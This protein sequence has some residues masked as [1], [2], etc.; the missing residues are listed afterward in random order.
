MP[1]SAG[2]L[3]VAGPA[4]IFPP[5]T[6]AGSTKIPRQECRAFIAGD[7]GLRGTSGTANQSPSIRAISGR[8]AGQPKQTGYTGSH[9]PA[10][11]RHRLW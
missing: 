5:D 6:N 4:E 11:G 7:A 2:S 9:R 10:P 8:F 3:L 1:G